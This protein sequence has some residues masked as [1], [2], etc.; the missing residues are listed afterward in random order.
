MPSATTGTNTTPSWTSIGIVDVSPGANQRASGIVGVGIGDCGAIGGVVSL[1][2]AA[3]RGG[4]GDGGGEIDG[5]G[6]GD[7]SGIADGDD[8]GAGAGEAEDDG[9]ADA[10]LPGDAGAA[11]GCGMARGATF[12]PA[13]APPAPI[14]IS[15]AHARLRNFTRRAFAPRRAAALLDGE[16]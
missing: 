2:P 13:L 3:S 1:M 9:D 16:L 12:A 6:K 15:S 4:F 14:A 7:G 10:A 8:D 11:L 5:D